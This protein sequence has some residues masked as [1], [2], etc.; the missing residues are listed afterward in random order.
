M[1]K[2]RQQHTYL[3]KGFS[4]VEL[5]IY[6]GIFSIL[7]VVLTQMYT[8]LYEV[9]QSSQSTSYVEQ[10]G[11]FILSR[12]TY[13]VQRASSVT[14][15]ASLGASSS[16]LQML[17]NGVTYTYTVTGQK[18]TINGTQLNSFNTNTTAFSAQR[19]GNVGGK[20]TVKVSFT[21][22]SLVATT[23]AQIKTFQTTAGLR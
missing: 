11:R 16:T 4:L 3:K 2:A 13:D 7:I 8:S 21:L 22:Q 20:D 9:Q 14:S 17:I 23:S 1:I 18:L 6:V 5:I 15:P 12:L 19:L 10:D